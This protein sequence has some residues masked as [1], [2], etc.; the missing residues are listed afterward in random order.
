MTR[1]PAALAKEPAP[2]VLSV[3][4]WAG[5]DPSCD[6]PVLRG[7]PPVEYSSEQHT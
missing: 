2:V 6:A 5:P 7:T 1:L 3:D 4:D